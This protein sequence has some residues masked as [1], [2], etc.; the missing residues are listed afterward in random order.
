MSDFH[1]VGGCHCG[2]VRYQL[3]TGP[4]MIYNCH[5]ANCQKISASAFSV[6]L[7]VMKTSFEI[8]SG[9][10]KRL[11]WPSDVGTQ[12]YGLLCGDCGTRICHGMVPDI[13]YLSLRGG[14]LDDTSWLTPV[15]DIWTDSA[16]KWIEF[17]G[18]RLSY[19]RQPEQ[20]DEIVAAYAKVAGR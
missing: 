5:C 19:P 11:E 18:K 7:T 17:S 3:N 13:D 12:R 20:Y 14:T 2:A 6:A 9:D 4:A 8:T 16:Q 1:Q 15:A 10:P